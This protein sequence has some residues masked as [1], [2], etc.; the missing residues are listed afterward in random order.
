VKRDDLSLG[1]VIKKRK[2]QRRA[3][4]SQGR[5]PRGLPLVLPP[6]PFV[7]TP[8]VCLLTH[9]NSFLSNISSTTLDVKWILKCFP[10]GSNN[11][12][13]MYIFYS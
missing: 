2:R 7:L 4:H 12:S 13:F 6:L 11:I 9:S 5:R 3:L 8:I 10:P 1:V